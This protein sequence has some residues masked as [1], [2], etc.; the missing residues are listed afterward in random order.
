MAITTRMAAQIKTMTT[1]AHPAQRG[2]GRFGVAGAGGGGAAHGCVWVM[3]DVGGGGVVYGW[4]MEDGGGAVSVTGDEGRVGSDGSGLPQRGQNRACG[5]AVAPQAGQM[6]VGIVGGVA[7]GARNASPHCLQKRA[8]GRFS[9]PHFEH[10][11]GGPLNADLGR[12]AGVLWCSYL[13]IVKLKNS[14]ITSTDE[15]YHYAGFSLA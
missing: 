8:L 12:T 14:C 9:R 5:L 4:V 1:T 10:F 7:C 3:G 13:E 6:F 15:F 11:I 2:K